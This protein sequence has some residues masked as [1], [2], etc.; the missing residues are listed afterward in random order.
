MEMAKRG[1]RM[2][3][4]GQGHLAPLKLN[5]NMREM[6]AVSSKRKY[7]IIFGGGIIEK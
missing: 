4:R 1:N 7:H 6:G 3:N 2:K 5:K